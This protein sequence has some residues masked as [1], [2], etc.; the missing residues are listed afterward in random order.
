MCTMW[1]TAFFDFS[2]VGHCKWTREMLELLRYF[3]SHG[4]C[5]QQ[6]IFVS[7]KVDFV[8][9]PY[10]AKDGPYLGKIVKLT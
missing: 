5:G 9:I 10:K 8:Y 3:G 6:L 4:C 1:Q 7:D 2:K